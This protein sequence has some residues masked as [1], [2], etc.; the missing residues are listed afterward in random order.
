[1]TGKKRTPLAPDIPTMIELG[2]PELDSDAWWAMWGPP[3]MPND[4]VMTINGWVNDAV[5]ALGAEG[6]LT[7]LGIEPLAESPAAFAQFIRADYDRSSRLLKAANF[8]PQ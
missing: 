3:G 6:R 4:L 5:K 2:Q 8:H 7:A 1:V